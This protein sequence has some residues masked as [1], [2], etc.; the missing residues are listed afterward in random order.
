MEFESNRNKRDGVAAHGKKETNWCSSFDTSL[1][2]QFHPVPEFRDRK[3]RAP[4][5]SLNVEF[6]HIQRVQHGKPSFLKLVKRQQNESALLS[7]VF[8]IRSV[9][10]VP[11]IP[12]YQ[13]LLTE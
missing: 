4:L 9:F 6:L 1:A 5:Q 8:I 3:N 7:F 12:Q 13:A 2:A 10:Y 11:H